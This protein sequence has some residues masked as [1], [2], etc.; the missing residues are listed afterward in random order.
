[1]ASKRMIS[2][3]V[4]VAALCMSVASGF[5]LPGVAPV[6]FDEGESVDLKVNKL[7]SVH[8]QLPYK[9]YALPFCKPDQIKDKVENIGE[10]LRGDRIENSLYELRANIPERCKVLCNRTYDLKQIEKFSE[11]VGYEYRVHWIVDNLPAATP[12]MLQDANGKTTIVYESGFPLGIQ[13]EVD[14]NGG[15]KHAV[16]YL[17]NHVNIKLLY[18]K[19]PEAYEGLRIVGFEVEPESIQHSSYVPGGYP[20]TCVNRDTGVPFQA[21]VIPPGK[22]ELLIIFTYSVTWEPSDIP[23]ANRWDKYLL[24]TDPQIHWFSIINSLMIVLFLTGMVAMIMMRTLHADFRRYNSMDPNE[25]AEETGWKLVHGDVF[26]PPGRPMLLSV[27][28]GSG[29]QILGMTV[30]TMIFAVLGFLSPANRGGLMTAMV[31]LFVVMG[32]FAGYSSTRTY[33]MFKGQ[34]WK[35]NT[36]MTAFLF[37]G[38]IFCIFFILNL[39]IWGQK[40]SGAVPFG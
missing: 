7:T 37:P 22:S 3:F 16:N 26:R 17:N 4:V 6:E 32:V 34:A 15:S 14:E 11:F 2:L 30:V 24:N 20:E 9:Y 8:T 36:L 21:L 19:N 10:I 23:W 40:S 31:V 25:E 35:K 27:L 1:M 12:K 28:I 38:V 13:G 33:R 39:F 18:H 29:V 5:Y